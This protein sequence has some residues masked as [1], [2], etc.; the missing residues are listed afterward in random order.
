ML[1]FVV[2]GI[3]LMLTPI[4]MTV[5]WVGVALGVARPAVFAV[6]AGWGC[7]DERTDVTLGH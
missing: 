3:G 7:G 6:M 1:G 2:G 5:F 4:N